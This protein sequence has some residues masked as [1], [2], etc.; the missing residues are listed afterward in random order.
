M[1]I[2]KIGTDGM[3]PSV[4]LVTPIVQYTMGVGGA[5]PSGSGSGITFPATQNASSN[6]NTLDDYE[7]GTWTPDVYNTGSSSTFSTRIGAYRKI[8][9]VV[10]AWWYCDYGNT[11]TAGTNLAIGGLPFTVSVEQYSAIGIWSC[12]GGSV[13]NGGVL[14]AGGTGYIYQGGSNM[15]EQFTYCGGTI[16]YW[17]A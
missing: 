5:T 3:S 9:S 16:T 1:A 11:G 7:E 15:T 8:G 4:T 10:T 12:N 6:A 14:S 17:T 2:S 13:R